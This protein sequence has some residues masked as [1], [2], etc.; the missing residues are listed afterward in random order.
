MAD[1]TRRIDE[2]LENLAVELG[3]A[4]LALDDE[5]QCLIEIDDQ[6]LLIQHFDEPELAVLHI[7]LGPIPESAELE[8]LRTLMVAN[9]SWRETGGGALGLAPDSGHAV[10]MARLDLAEV[11]AERFVDRVGD[12][13][14]AAGQ[15]ARRIRGS[16]AAQ[17][18]HMQDD[19]HLL[20]QPIRA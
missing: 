4:G 15:W 16:A 8:V 6:V 19:G 18:R 12:L 20:G 13:V 17:A 14:Q 10:L 2:A 11:N 5:D 9:T 7:D 3:L 1:G